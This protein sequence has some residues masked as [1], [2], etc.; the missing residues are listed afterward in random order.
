MSLISSDDLNYMRDYAE[1]WMPDTCQIENF[2]RVSDGAGG[3]TESWLAVG[4]VA[5]RIDPAAQSSE[6][7][8]KISGRDTLKSLYVITLP[9]DCGLTDEHRIVFS[10]NVYQVLKL[11]SA[12]SGKVV[13]R[14][15]IARYD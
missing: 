12:H 1:S 4:T 3:F 8:F 13:I 11:D 7:D 6:M 2:V 10:G 5:C 14:A 15:R 9:Y